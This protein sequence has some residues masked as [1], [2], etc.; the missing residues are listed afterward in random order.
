MDK[1]KFICTMCG[2]Q[3]ETRGVMVWSQGKMVCPDCKKIVKKSD[4]R[5]FDRHIENRV[6][7]HDKS[8]NWLP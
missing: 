8:D 3:E 7:E 1:T 5:A 6:Y 4:E 2:R